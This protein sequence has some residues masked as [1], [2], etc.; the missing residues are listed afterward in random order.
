MRR[1]L[2][3]LVRQH[4]NQWFRRVGN[5]DWSPVLTIKEFN[6]RFL[7]YLKWKRLALACSESDFRK[8]MCEFLCTAYT[9]HKQNTVWTGPLSSPIRPVGWTHAHEVEWDNYISMYV[10]T[11]EVWAG[12]WSGIPEAMWESRVPSWRDQIQSVVFHYVQVDPRKIESCVED[13]GSVHS[14]EDD[15]SKRMYD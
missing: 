3:D 13:C 15:D 14:D 4:V 12:F 10:F 11:Y 9:A 6:D 7:E 1:N 8:A 2:R 5:D